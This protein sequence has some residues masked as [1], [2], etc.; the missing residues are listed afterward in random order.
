MTSS[1]YAGSEGV[2][3]KPGMSTW[4]GLFI[5]FFGVLI[6]RQDRRLG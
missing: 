1:P 2:P 4:L 3:A 6:V 5:A